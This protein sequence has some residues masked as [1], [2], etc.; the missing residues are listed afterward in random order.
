MLNFSNCSFKG[1]PTYAKFAVNSLL[2]W[3]RNESIQVLIGP[4]WS[5][6]AL[7]AALTIA[8]WRVV[9]VLN[10]DYEIQYMQDPFA[11]FYWIN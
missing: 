10:M 2:K 6:T 7:P 9:Q 8:P 3:P 5:Q 1:S 4:A 11:S